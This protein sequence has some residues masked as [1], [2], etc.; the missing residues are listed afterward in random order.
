MKNGQ[1]VEVIREVDG[2]F[3]YAPVVYFD[4]DDDSDM[5]LDDDPLFTKDVYDSPPIFKLHDEVVRLQNEVQKLNSELI[6][7]NRA[8]RVMSDVASM[9]PQ[10][11]FVQ[12]LVDYLKG[13]F[14]YVLF[15]GNMELR[16]KD[17]VYI[18]PYIK[19]VRTKDGGFRMYKL[20]SEQYESFDD[21]PIR[22]FKTFDD[23]QIF[24]KKELITNL[25]FCT[26]AAQ[27]KWSYRVIKEKFNEIH[28]SCKLKNDAEVQELF[29]KKMAEA[30]ERENKD[31]TEK[32]R[33]EIE[34]KQK[35]LESIKG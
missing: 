34:E 7:I 19:I 32:L 4:G 28:S 35:Q 12:C 3:I 31:K 5:I 10:W 25:I 11:D 23:A 14:Q 29:N 20:R 8:K 18:S 6:E 13:D 21:I 30:E 1:E 17:S 2:G 9:I 15:L 22:I 24:A 27:Y 16:H 26:D 33:K